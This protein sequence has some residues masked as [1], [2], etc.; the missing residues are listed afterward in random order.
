MSPYNMFSAPGLWLLATS[1]VI[2]PSYRY[3]LYLILR[4]A[5]EFL[6]WWPVP[7]RLFSMPSYLTNASHR[8]ATGHFSS[9]YLA[10]WRSRRRDRGSEA[11]RELL[12]CS[13]IEGSLFRCWI[14]VTGCGPVARWGGLQTDAS[15]IWRCVLGVFHTAPRGRTATP[16]GSLLNSYMYICA[17]QSPTPRKSWFM[18]WY[19]R[20]HTD[21]R[22]GCIEGTEKIVCSALFWLRLGSPVR[23]ADGRHY[24]LP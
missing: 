14:V 24:H 2:R 6:Y 17:T 5:F 11:W 20:T 3:K 21:T 22:N 4:I 15:Q 16:V 7:N 12:P 10:R 18:A 9:Q 23:G 1:H 8:L 13:S 19:N